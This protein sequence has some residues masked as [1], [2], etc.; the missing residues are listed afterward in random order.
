MTP[1][2]ARRVL[3]VFIGFALFSRSTSA[4]ITRPDLAD[5]QALKEAG[6]SPD[7]T[8]LL[9]FFRAR[10][11]TDIDSDRLRS[12]LQKFAADADEERSRATA[13]FLGLG[14]LAV[15]TLRH[16]VNDLNQP[17]LARRAEHCLQWIE[18]PSHST[19]PAA[20]ARV[21][22]RCKPNG[23]AEALL[24]YLPFADNA[25]V[26]GAITNAL[27]AVA[28]PGGR[29]DPALL[30]GLT[31]PVAVR[32]VAAGVALCRATPPDSVPEVRKILKD[33]APGVRL[34]GAMAL[35]EANDAE[36]I[37]VLIDLLA[38]LPPEQR[39]PIEEYLTQLAG[40]WA[41]GTGLA[42]EDEIARKIRRDIWAAW[43]RNVDGPALLAVVRART[44][45]AEDRD[46]IRGLIGKLGADEF[47]A[48]ESASRALF[49]LGRRSLP[50]LREALKERDIEVVRRVKLLLERIEQEPVHHL[51]SAAIRLLAMRKPAGAVEA[52]LAYLPFVEDENLSAE[53]RKSL[54]AL[55]LQEGK[56]DPALVR[57]LDDARPDLRSIAAEALA[58]GGA[59]GRS[60]ARKLLR[61]GDPEVRLRAA[62]AL[63]MAHDS[64]GV[65]VLIDL[66]TVLNA[67]RVG[68]VEDALHQLAGESAP[69]V[70]LGADSAQRKK[71][72]EAWA[73]WWKVNAGRVEL[74]RLTSRPWL[75]FT[76]LCDCNRNRVYEIGRDGK[77]RWAIDNVPFPVDAWVLPGNRVLIAE[78]RGQRVSERDF[79]GKVLWSKDGLPGAPVNVQRLS[80]GN[81]FIATQMFIL[82]VDRAGKEVY[83]IDGKVLRGITAACRARDGHIVCLAQTGQCLIL[84]TTGRQL[85][86]FPSNR[87]AGWTSGLDLSA[88]GHILITQPDRN[89]VAEF[90][91]EGKQVLEVDALAPTTATS[92]PNGHILV[93]SHGGQRV[94]EMDRAGKVVWE[95]K[96]SGPIFRARRR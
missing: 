77:E 51:P 17:D 11:R 67:E 21:V 7:G 31:D 16:A 62:L 81:T 59:E 8:A 3:L 89:K 15:P 26:L 48:R 56:P 66:L 37:P 94:F 1:L 93:A 82:E 88:N 42:G 84:D 39:R 47:T 95:H 34:R 72:R 92:L 52:L 6:L 24:T 80:N 50:Q 60:A 55:A 30:R 46:K 68:Q 43:W 86:S 13:E 58:G 96:A 79:K 25:D 35:A 85:K 53:V 40:E 38:E 27:A 49:A 54:T 64:E 41:P 75:G 44:L 61:D 18:G 20:A 73:A 19:L 78:Y 4:Q 91:A 69:Q 23:A 5:E 57:L 90:D 83:T 63:T 33:P 65:P 12:L 10:S 74:S 22:A 36:A 76:L 70:S 2:P 14:P 32:R 9:A 29:P 71:C 45:T 28:A 87:Q